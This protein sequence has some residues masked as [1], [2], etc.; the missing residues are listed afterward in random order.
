MNRAGMPVLA[1]DRQGFS[2]EFGYRLVSLKE[3]LG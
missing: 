2:V 3:F 1:L